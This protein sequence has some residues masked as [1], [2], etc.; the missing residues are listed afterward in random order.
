M[1]WYTKLENPKTYLLGFLKWLI[2]GGLLGA[3]GGLLGTFFHWVLEEV[4]VLRTAQPILIYF[5]PVVGLV[6]VGLYKLTGMDK[7]RG[8]NEMI[9]AVNEKRD[10]NPLLVPAIFIAT[11]LTH[12]FGGS[13]GREG[14]ALQLG[15]TL[16][17]IVG[18]LLHLSPEDRQVM[19]LSGMS[20][21]FAALF[22]TPLTA[23]L[24]SVEF[25]AVGNF[26]GPGFLPSL[27]AAFTASRIALAFGATPTAFALEKTQPLSVAGIAQTAVLA[28]LVALVSM[29]FCFVMHKTEQ[30]LA[31]WLPNPFIRIFV[32]GCAVVLLTIILRTH[33]YNGAGMDVVARAILQG[34]A[35][36]W[37]FALKIIFTAITLGSGYK[38]GEIVPTFFV[39]ATFGCA[40]APL[41][42]MDPGIAAA[43]GMVGMF[44][45]VTNSPFTSIIMGIE[46][47]GGAH[48]LPF[49][50][51]CA[52]G[53]VLSGNSG[54]YASQ[55]I[56]YSKIAPEIVNR[57]AS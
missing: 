51:M 38:G 18:R 27:V 52:I 2:L 25:I 8:T 10:I 50:I 28:V 35:L 14:A 49:A 30:K 19:I 32:G 45:C 34:Q 5:L 46:I 57:H 3:V 24:F 48:L 16:G 55:R 43:L 31:K 11:A 17:S 20:A 44:C 6:I 54:L 22:G 15:G 12:L 53:F 36:P 29:A 26:F 39:G 56:V 41:L 4:G 13:A 47:F 1:A 9:D 33:D 7:T 23:A 40:V 37:A 21:V 42:G